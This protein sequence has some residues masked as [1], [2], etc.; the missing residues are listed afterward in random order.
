MSG[1]NPWAAFFFFTDRDERPA[2]ASFAALAAALGAGLATAA[3][4]QWQAN[5]AGAV[6]VGVP[7]LGLLA[8]AGT[9]RRV[10][11]LLAALGAWVVFRINPESPSAAVAL[12]HHL[13]YFAVPP[14]LA[15]LM[16]AEADRD[17]LHLGYAHLYAPAAVMAAGAAVHLAMRWGPR[18]QEGEREIRRAA[19]VYGSCYVLLLLVGLGSRL[20]SVQA[21]PRGAV[22]TVAVPRAVELE[23]QGRY[24]VAARVYER[25]GQV[26]KA[27]QAAERAGEW[28]RAARLYRRAGQ[29]FQAAEMF[30]RAHLL[31]EA[32]QSYE[33]ARDWAAA[34]RL[35]LQLGQVDRAVDLYEKGG[36]KMAALKA[37]E[38]SGRKPHPEQYRRA[39]LME[40]AARAH[41]ERGDWLRAGE[42][43]EHD[44]QDVERA[45]LMYQ[46]AG[47]H[48]RA[49][50]LLEAR[51]YTQQALRQYL[52]DPAGTLQAARIYLAAGRSQDAA[53]LLARMPA[54]ELAKLEDEAMLTVV[55]R[56]MLEG[57]RHDEAAR[58]LQGLKRRGNAGGAVRLLL[59]RSFLGKG[60]Q[61]LAEQELRA[62][63]SMPL[64][65]A[66][67]IEA[68][69][70][71]GCVLEASDQGEEALKTFLEVLEK[72]VHY[73]DAEERYRKL[74]AKVA[75]PRAPVP[76]E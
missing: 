25:E 75:G 4:P 50:H 60:L 8:M 71:L 44:L 62:A 35:C 45:V 41:R 1:F 68:A 30:Y 57:G 13:A 26:E 20:R 54:E 27:A 33:E 36:D 15:D 73:K 59:G 58:I 24:G 21:K 32:L 38:E 66:E 49:A 64:D 2:Q 40:E 16:M 14:L 42:V 19:L 65:P 69:Y 28:E 12:V 47:S 29:D 22:G 48:L 3:N 56:V 72:D 70:L 39:G 11:F 9:A 34:A 17:R 37:L 18:F 5:L 67:E 46:K 7:V 31:P 43:Y 76:T 53:E 52:A 10:F 51:G 23:E 61:S 55:A 63:T 74:K 6:L